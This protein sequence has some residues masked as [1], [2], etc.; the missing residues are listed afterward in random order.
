M[1][2]STN[3]FYISGQKIDILGIKRFLEI[4]FCYAEKNY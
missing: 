1:Y 2:T 4:Y 3:N